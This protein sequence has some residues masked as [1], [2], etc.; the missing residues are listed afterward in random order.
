MPSMPPSQCNATGCKAPSIPHSRYCAQHAPAPR[1]RD[2]ERDALYKG[3]AWAR[4]R[5]AQLS[6]HPLC[7]ACASMGRVTQGA[8][9]DHVFPWRAIGPQA[10]R[11]N[12]LQTLCGPCH[13]RKSALEA[14][15]TFRHYTPSGP[16]DYTLPDW[17]RIAAR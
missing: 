5:Q 15:G 7:Q 13:S 4:M 6:A 8:H 1:T 11:V 17:A 9:V 14:R 2:H 10:F 12:V 16:R 3:A